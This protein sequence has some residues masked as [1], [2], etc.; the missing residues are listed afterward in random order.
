MPEEVLTVKEVTKLLKLAEKTLYTIASFG[1]FQA[2]KVGK[3]WRIK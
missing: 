1:E 2:F 3:Q